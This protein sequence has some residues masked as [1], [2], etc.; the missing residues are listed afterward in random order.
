[1]RTP[2]AGQDERIPVALYF[3]YICPFCYVA[4]HRL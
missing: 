3:D 2:A 1:M 4:S